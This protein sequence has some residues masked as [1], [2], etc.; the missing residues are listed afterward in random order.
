MNIISRCISWVAQALST[1]LPLSPFRDFIDCLEAV[2]YLG[3]LNFFVPVREILVVMTAWLG[4]IAL[5][6]GYSI[7]MRWLKVLGD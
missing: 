4:A 1:I 6:Y 7:I 2:P 5:F 3:W